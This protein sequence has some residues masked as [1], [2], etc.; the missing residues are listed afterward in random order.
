[1]AWKFLIPGISINCILLIEIMKKIFMKPTTRNYFY[2][3]MEYLTKPHVRKFEIGCA[4]FRNWKR[5]L[6]ILFI[7]GLITSI[8]VAA[9][10]D[11][12]RDS[13]Q[14]IK[15]TVET[16]HRWTPPF[17]VER[18]GRPLDAV[19][20]VPAGVKP[21]EEYSVVGY[22][23]GEETS[24]RIVTIEDQFNKGSAWLFGSSDI[25]QWFGRVTL[26]DWPSEVVLTLKS[27]SQ[28]AAIEVARAKV[29]PPV[30][31][32]EAVVHPDRVIHPVDLG[33]IL[34]PDGWLLLA[35]GQRA[36]VEI[37]AL[38]RGSAIVG[39]KVVAWYE[40]MPLQKTYLGIQLL[41]GNR[42]LM[43][44]DL[45]PDKASLKQD[46]LHVL[47]ADGAG[48]EL[49][50][51]VIP[52]M[53][54]PKPSHV[55]QFGAI[56]TKLRYDEPIP[57]KY[58]PYKIS[59]ENGWDQ[60]LNDVV[61][62]LPNGARFVLWRGSSYC[63]FW[64]SRSNTGL[65]HEWAEINR[66]KH[67]V[68][69][70]DCVEPLQDKELRYGRVKIVES[71]PSRVH[72][73]W[74]YQSCDVDY[75]VWGEFA[76]EDYYF[77]PDGFGTR[78]MTV[79]MRTGSPLETTEFIILLPQ[80]GYA[81][82]Y[83]SGTAFDLLWPEG[84][85]SFR[86]PCRP[87][88]DGQEEQ[89]S[90]LKEVSKETCLLHR[91]RFGENDPLAAIQYSPLGS[92]HDL[93]GFRPFHDRGVEATPMYWGCHWP[94]SR[95]YG[96]GWGIS[97]R[98]NETPGHMSAY[99]AGTPKPLRTQTGLM[100]NA[101][102]E[103]H[104]MTRQTFFWLI[105]A[106][107][108]DDDRLRHWMQSAGHPPGLE[109]SGAR[110]DDE[111]FVPERRTLCLVVESQKVKVTIKPDAW[112]MNPVFELRNAPSKLKRVSL[113]GRKMGLHQYAWDGKILWID[114]ALSQPAEL[115]LEFEKQ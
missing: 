77:Y 51:K 3:D 91:I 75:K 41:K 52:V 24:R 21:G 23:D 78:V 73:R 43:K 1:M 7:T 113:N 36:S 65:C 19:L 62:F 108:S 30:F 15:F 104:E 103:T 33:T 81:F 114:A 107:D 90:R 5:L 112:Y 12:A 72:V 106:T 17:G 115:F 4:N 70:K 38:N 68:G 98:I 53:L 28:V 93:P 2:I 45:G 102:G 63:P 11:K 61:V 32:A 20:E 46:K 86:F 74:D 87:G 64:A 69:I 101:L 111:F 48:K 47:I 67:Q 14:T 85:S 92:W 55:P 58:A 39:A 13:V 8:S 59:Y 96:T 37:A 26:D 31:E 110:K 6:I 88:I 27:S 22:R 16:G 42:S 34:V 57:A 10:P 83:L 40:S 54:V 97:E 60:E 100:L 35:D 66:A 105:G 25:K 80:S 99:H 109:L 89:W 95:G 84:K 82:K 9:E 49:W 71:T 79:T 94:L 29:Y 18:V 50:H 76:S 56:E 44:F